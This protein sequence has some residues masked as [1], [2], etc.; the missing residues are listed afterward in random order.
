MLFHY[1]RIY[2][3]ILGIN[4][5]IDFDIEYL[6]VVWNGIW[7]GLGDCWFWGRGRARGWDLKGRYNL[8]EGEGREGR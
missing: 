8:E 5:I 6:I 1:D 7:W 4:F 3:F 2:R